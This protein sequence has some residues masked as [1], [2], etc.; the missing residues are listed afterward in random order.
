MRRKKNY[1][2][3]KRAT[4]KRVTLP[5]GRTFVARC[6]RVPRSE[7]PAHICMNRTYRGGVAKGRQHRRQQRGRGLIPTLK[8]IAKH[9]ITKQLIRTGAKHLPDLYAKGTS[10]IKNPRFKKIL[11]S[12]VAKKIVNKLHE[13]GMEQ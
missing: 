7:L 12:K 13:K 1:V 11:E 6:E 10:K 5:N 9:P 3:R 4:P 8:K 2:M